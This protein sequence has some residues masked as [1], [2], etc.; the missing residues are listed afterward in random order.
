[1]WPDRVYNPGP[2]TYESGA[3]P[4]VLPGT[5]HMIQLEQNSFWNFAEVNF[6]ECFS[7]S[8]RGLISYCI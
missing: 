5:A 4:T 8:N 1:M 2:L 7:H 6:V 3:L